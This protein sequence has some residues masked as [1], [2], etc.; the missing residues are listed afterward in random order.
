[1]RQAFT[2]NTTLLGI[3]TSRIPDNDHPTPTDTTKKRA[4]HSSQ[5][6]NAVRYFAAFLYVPYFLEAGFEGWGQD[7]AISKTISTPSFLPPTPLLPLPTRARLTADIKTTHSPPKHQ[8]PWVFLATPATSARPLVLS[9]PPT[10][11]S[12]PSNS[13]ASPP[14]PVLALSVSSLHDFHA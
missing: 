3:F 4:L 7:S 10:A 5:L 8:E 9:V 14:I 6:D 11:R 1:M 2:H 12:V 13:A